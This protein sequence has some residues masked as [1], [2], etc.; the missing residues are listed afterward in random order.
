M[1]DQADR[2]RIENMKQYGFGIEA[3]KQT[4]I[5]ST[6]KNT[7]SANQIFCTKCGHR[8]PDKTLYELYKE[9]HKCCPAC[10]TVVATQTEYCPQCGKKI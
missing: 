1:R 8:L 10:D 7:S 5:C 6:C 2:I 4:K 3:M 9:R